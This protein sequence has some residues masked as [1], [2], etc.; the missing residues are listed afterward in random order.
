MIVQLNYFPLIA[1]F[2]M[3][4][5]RPVY[6]GNEKDQI[7]LRMEMDKLLLFRS[8]SILKFGNS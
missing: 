4:I 8:Q 5:A 7:F 1:L 2:S 3:S 6:G